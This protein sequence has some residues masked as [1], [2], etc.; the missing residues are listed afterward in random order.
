MKALKII[1]YFPK[2]TAQSGN[3]AKNTVL[4]LFAPHKTL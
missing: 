1:C 4:D 3:V 2:H